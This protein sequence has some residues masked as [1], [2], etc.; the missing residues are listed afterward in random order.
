MNQDIGVI[1]PGRRSAANRLET[2]VGAF[3]ALFLFG[4]AFSI[5]MAQITFGLSLAAFA[6]WIIVSRRWPEGLGPRLVYLAI[7]SYVGW[8]VIASVAGTSPLASLAALRE[9][10]LFAILPVGIFLG[11]NQSVRSRLLIA[12]AI[13]T[14]LAGTYGIVQHFT[15]VYWFKSGTL[16]V[17]G[18]N[19]RLAGNFSHPLTYGYFVATSS[20]FLL[21]YL[22]A[23]PKNQSRLVRVLLL[24]ATLTS[25]TATALCLSRGPLLALVVGLIATGL[26]RRQFVR[27]AIGLMLVVAVIWIAAPGLVAEYTSRLNTDLDPED[28]GSRLYIWNQSAEIIA[29][30]P[31]T[32]VGPGSF[33]EA[34]SDLLPAEAIPHEHQGHAHNDFLNLAA[35]TGVPGLLLYLS[36]WGIVM[37]ELWRRSRNNDVSPDSRALATAALVASVVFC[38]A[39]MTEAAFADEELRQLITALWAFGLIDS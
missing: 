1:S 20:V 21:N 8:L 39:S 32:G 18:D 27:P 19:Y 23:S 29:D 38:T 22:I 30:N 11:R 6:G 9:E 16:H 5:A 14:L 31:L 36:I 26:I 25:L 17:V 37:V 13:G 15:G 12:L 2:A 28:R 35:T 3:F 33:H 7:G 24:A 34:Y 10:W 4:S